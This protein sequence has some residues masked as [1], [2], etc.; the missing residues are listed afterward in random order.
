MIKQ[1]KM[2]NVTLVALMIIH[3]VLGELLI[4]QF[5]QLEVSFIK[6]PKQ[7]KICKIQYDDKIMD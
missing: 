7:E 3:I 5:K 4:N 1:S 6:H 2:V